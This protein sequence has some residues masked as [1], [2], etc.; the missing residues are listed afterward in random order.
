MDRRPRI[1]VELA[2]QILR[3]TMTAGQQVD[4]FDAPVRLALRCQWAHCPERWPLVQFWEGCRGGHDIG[5]SQSK[6]ASFNGIIRQ[7]ADRAPGA[8]FQ[9][10]SE[11]ICR[12][13]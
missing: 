1:T 8:I 2:V 7:C 4:E 12:P 6:T 10:I 5:R 13:R 9:L 11:P 3:S